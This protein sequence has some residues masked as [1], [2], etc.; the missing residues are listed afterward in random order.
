MA[1]QSTRL[2]PS[3]IRKV[4]A[5]KRVLTDARISVVQII[6]FGSQVKGTAHA[7][8]DIDVAIVS[9][10]FGKDYHNELVRLSKL[11]DNDTID[12]EPHPFHPDDLNNR[13]STL[14][15]EIRQHGIEV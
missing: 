15:Q 9:P 14:A 1:K 8:S 11:C 13:W 3:I 4:H 10:S 2:K 6:V 5:Y 7:D 12:I